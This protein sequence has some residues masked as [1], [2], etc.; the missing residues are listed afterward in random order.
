MATVSA[1]FGKAEP[2]EQRPALSILRENPARELV[3]PRRT[4]GFDERSEHRATCSLP[5]LVPCDIDRELTNAR[6]T[7]SRAVWKRRG[8]S[9]DVLL[10]LRH[11]NQRAGSQPFKYLCRRA[12]FGLEG[13]DAIRNTLTVNSGYSR[14]IRK[15]GRARSVGGH[16]T[17]SY[18]LVVRIVG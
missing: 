2:L 9:N 1:D 10:N 5:T 12:G 7:R 14:R 8:E 6:V 18:Q 17:I 4:S 16:L 15:C 13:S 11:E 3:Q